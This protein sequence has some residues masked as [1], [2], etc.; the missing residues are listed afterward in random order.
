MHRMSL[1]SETF[2][3]VQLEH[4]KHFPRASDRTAVLLT[5]QACFSPHTSAAQCSP[6]RPFKLIHYVLSTTGY[7]GMWYRSSGPAA[8][9][10]YSTSG[11]F[12]EDDTPKVPWYQVF[13]LWAYIQGYI[14]PH[15]HNSIGRIAFWHMACY[16]TALVCCS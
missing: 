15:R 8:Q 13:I 14:R 12:P 5:S 16:Q 3:S 11:A 7:D 4:A 1:L 6:I 9:S 2:W 10:W